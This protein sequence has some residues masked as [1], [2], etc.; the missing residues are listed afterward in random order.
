LLRNGLA[1]RP[2]GE[3]YQFGY[4]YSELTRAETE[5]RERKRGLWA[6]AQPK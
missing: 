2:Q 5:A 6:A 1:T 4:K 3:D